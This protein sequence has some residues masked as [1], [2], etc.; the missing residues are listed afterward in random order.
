MS[1]VGGD[2]QSEDARLVERAKAGDAGAVGELFTRHRHRLRR[3]VELRL[4][5][6]LQARVDASD[7]IQEAYV[8]V[9]AR[10]DEYL[11]GPKLPLFLWLRLVVGERLMK[12]HRHHL[13]TQMRDAN[14][15]VSLYRGA[16]PAASSMALAA[17]L[18][19]RHTSPTQAAVRAERLLHLQSALNDLDPLD[20]EILCLRHFE[21]LTHA[22]A[23]R[24]LDIEEAAAAKRYIRAM[25]RLKG[26]LTSTPGGNEGL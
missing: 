3:M 18:L 17:Q 21:E 8:D 4:D 6:R 2:Q 26:I 23:A 5:H 11:A 10:L 13:G 14:R 22:E 25:K 24:V 9:A 20:R 12:A 19:G 16:L 15:E 1:H 7:V